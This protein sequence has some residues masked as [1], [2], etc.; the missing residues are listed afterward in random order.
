MCQSG[1]KVLEP[2]TASCGATP[3]RP[4]VVRAA[5]MCCNRR[6]LIAL[7]GV[8]TSISEW[9]IAIRLCEY[10]V[11]APLRKHSVKKVDRPDRV[12]GAKKR[13]RLAGRASP[14]PP[15]GRLIRHKALVKSHS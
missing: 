7:A 14:T 9:P 6:P 3:N 8:S 1:S 10:S 5:I 11:G 2:M 13:H 15:S 12:E 4:R